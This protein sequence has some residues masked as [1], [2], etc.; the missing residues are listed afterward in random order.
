MTTI[1]YRDGVLAADTAL[2]R[3]DSLHGRVVKVGKSPSGLLGGACGDATF[4]HAFVGWLEAEQGERPKPQDRDG[5]TAVLIHQDGRIECIEHGGSF[6]VEAAYWAIGSGRPEALGAMFAGAGA[7]VAVR[8]A[9]AHDAHTGG[10]VT[11]VT[12]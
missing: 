1:A 11:V 8:A 7:E 5:G 10:D 2:S 3:G 6:V 4:T 12:Q 9:M